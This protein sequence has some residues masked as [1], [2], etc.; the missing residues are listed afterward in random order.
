MAEGISQNSRRIARNTIALYFRTIFLLVIKLYTA[1]IVLNALGVEDRGIYET[2]GSFVA[3]TSIL[4]GSLSTSI[5]RFL[6]VE[7]GRG[8]MEHLRRVFANSRTIMILLAALVLLVFEPLGIWQVSNVMQ[9]PPGRLAAAHWAFQF[10][11]LTFVFTLFS[12]PYNAV[13]I[14]HERMTV[15]A[16]I[17]IFE[18]IGR[19]LVGVAIFFFGGDRLILYAALMCL[20]AVLVRFLNVIYCRKFFSETRVGLGFDKSLFGRMF[21]FAGW[22]GLS[23]GIYILNTQGV[24]QLLNYFFGVVFN[25]MRG[26]AGNVETAVKQFV[27]N[28]IT[29]IN[30]QITKSYSSGDKDYAFNLTCKGAKY[31]YLIVFALALPFFF[32]ADTLLRLWLGGIVPDGTA[33]FTKLTLICMVLDIMM[34]TFSTLVQADGRI[35]KFYLVTSAIT[36]LIFPLTWI[37]FKAGAPAYSMYLV[38]IGVYLVAD[39]V[40]LWLL[41]ELT[42]FDIRLFADEVLKKILPVTVI[43]LAVTLLV[44]LAVPAG[45]WRLVAVLCIGTLAVVIST[46]FFGLSKGEKA[47]VDSKIM[48]KIRP[49]LL[50][51]CHSKVVDRDWIRWKGRPVDWDSPRDINEK[52]QWLMCCS[53]TSLWS[54]CSDK[55]RVREYVAGKGFADLL[56]PLLGKW[57]RAEDID[58]D[59]LPEKFAI[60]CNHDSGS[61]HIV[62]KNAGFDS[63][64]V[65]KDLAKHL[66]VKYGYVH[67]ELYYNDIKPC[68]IAEKFLEHPEGQASVIDYKVWAFNGK[69][70]CVWTCSDRTAGSVYVNVYDLDWKVRPEA[71]VFTEHYRDG[72]GRVP[73]PEFLDRMLHAA[74]VLS[75]GFPEVRVDF[76]EAGGKLY[77]GELTFASYCGKMDFYT[78][79][80]LEELGRQCIL[81]DKK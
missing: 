35:R 3:M 15:F 6:T 66:K 42:G 38:F 39:A 5:S 18:G 64:A 73:R 71:S 48:V 75:E 76:Y 59:A 53:D 11:L 32:E 2:V 24:T 69:P 26:L 1:R 37:L 49:F 63:D 79:E 29:A 80:F 25:T 16:F 65:R 13:I 52:I 55:Y 62:D 45:L 50:D 68:V 7:I 30:P 34:T 21:G 31:A 14:A 58:F 10:S 72:G 78:D 67:G 57:D 28:V 47:F 70:Y 77:F 41:K 81:P 40:K 19:F 36:V 27:V 20:V 56:V 54:L 60:K 9:I 8:N 17:G 33:L 51:H 46:Y 44:W 43:S 23:Y 74:S 12:I 4:T 61:A 22:N